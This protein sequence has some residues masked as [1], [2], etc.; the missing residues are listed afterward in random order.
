MAPRDLAQVLIDQLSSLEVGPAAES[1]AGRALARMDPVE[2]AY[3]LEALVTRARGSRPA[4]H[5]LVVA[6]RAL[7]L[8]GEA[9][10]SEEQKGRIYDAATEFGLPEAAALFV[11]DAPLREVDPTLHAPP[12]PVIGQLT[13]GHKKML[14]RR[15]DRDRIGR[16]A[17]EADARVI[18]ELLLNPRLTEEIVLNIAA[19][20]PARIPVLLELWRS[21]RW[22]AR[23]R[24]RQALA[25]NPYTPPDVALKLVP[26][27]VLADLR[28]M[29]QDGSLH[30]SVREL[31][32]RLAERR[33][34]SAARRS[35]DQP[36]EE[37]ADRP[38]AAGQDDQ[39]EHEG[40]E[41][42]FAAGQFEAGHRRSN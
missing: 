24:V 3:V 32:R 16:F 34:P 20:R 41:G 11:R 35:L 30:A 22:S 6:G 42:D 26:H 14:A 1:A 15:A 12:D 25:M 36:T 9:D 18:R 5:A 2:A 28:A 33:A 8:A 21:T 13:L 19:R 4:A 23:P 27:L 29:A 31:A 7:S 40:E 37:V 39:H 10:L 38:E 17:M